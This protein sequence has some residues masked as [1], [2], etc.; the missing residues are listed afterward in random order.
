MARKEHHS[1]NWGGPRKPK[2]GREA[3]LISPVRRTYVFEQKQIEKLKR[4][5]EAREYSSLSAVLRDLVDEADEPS[6]T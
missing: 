5:A 3:F 2:G 1:E 4:I 6:I